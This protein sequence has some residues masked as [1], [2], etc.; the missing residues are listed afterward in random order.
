MNYI[1]FKS[2]G[3]ENAEWLE[4]P[5]VEEEVRQAVFHFCGDK[6]P[7]TDGFPLAFFQGFWNELKVDIRY[8]RISC[9]RESF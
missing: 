4:R 6:A 5:F 7:W 1:A 3:T 2:I 9:M 8:E